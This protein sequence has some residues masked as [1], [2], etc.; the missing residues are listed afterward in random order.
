MSRWKKI[1]IAAAM[2]VAVLMAA[3]YAFLSFY[4]FNKFKPMIA[5]TV[6]NA[7]GRELTIAGDIEFELGIRPTLIVEEVSFQNASWSST[8]DLVRVK[9]M[10][11]RVAFLPLIIGKFDF[12]HLVLIEPTVIAEFD[13]SGTSN[14]SFEMPGD[15]KDES[16][17]APLPLI[18]SDVII[19]KGRFIYKD[20]RSDVKFS[21][22][23][24]RLDAEIPG[25][26]EPL[27]LDFKGAFDDKP[28]TLRG[29]V[30]PIWAWVQP[31]YSLTANL[32]ATAGGTTAM[33]TGDLRDPINFKNLAFD[34]KAQ[35]SS[36]A[37]ITRRAGISGAPE[38]GAFKLSA[39]VSD[40]AGSLAVE[41]L[42]V[43]IG[44]QELVA[45]SLTGDLRDVFALQGVNL[46]FT[47]QGQDSANLTQFG[48]PALPERGAFQVSAQISDPEAK[49]FT[50][51]DLSVVLGEN[52]V[53]GQVILNLVEKNPLLTARLT[54]QKFRFGQ[55]NLD[56]KLT[57]PLEKPAI[58]KIDL[59]LGTPEL[60]EIRLNGIVDDL[61]ELQ[62]VDIDFQASGKDLANLEQITGQP[63]PV[64]GAFSA[65]GKVMIPIHKNLKI[66]DLKITVG[67]NNFT[68]A[69]NLD[70]KGEQ[71]QLEANLSLP[72]LDLPSVLLPHLAKEGWAEG[73]GQV[74]PIKLAVKLTGFTQEI[75]VKKVDLQAGTLASAELRLSGSVANLMAQHGIDLRFSLRGNELAKLKEIIAQPYLFAPMPGQGAYALT[76][77]VSDS[78]ANVF[79][80]DNFKFKLADTELTGRLDFNLAAQPPKYEV[81]LSAPKFNLK[82]FPIPK[83][84]AYANLNKIDD[85]GPL[86]INSKMILEGDQLSLTQLEMQA[87]TEQLAAVQIKGSIKDLTT[88]S[89]IDM[90][91]NF[92]GNEVANLAKITVQSIPLKGAYSIS[93][94][95][96]DPAQ[97]KYK[98]GDLVLKLGQN[99]ITGSLDLNLSA[100]QF[101]LATDLA[102]PKFTLQP[103][104][105]PALEDIS[106]IKDLGPLKLAL[107]LT[108]I[109]K[110]LSLDN[111]DFKL[112]REDLIEVV[113][114]GT[115]KDLSAVQGMKLEFS[116]MG[117]DMS[118][119]EKLGGPEVP[120]EGA[121]NVSG[122][123]I[124]PAPKIYK[125]PAFNAVWGKNKGKGWLE[126]N[127]SAKRPQLRAELSTEK[128]DLQPLFAEDK[129]ERTVKAQSAPPA[130]SKAQ[131]SKSK[132]KT[133]KTSAKKAKVFPAE[134]LPLEGLKEIDANIKFRDKQVLLPALALDDV[135]LDIFL[136]DGNLEIKPFKFKI[137]GGNADVQ[138]ALRSQENPAALATNLNI[139]QL[140]IGPMLDK[141]RYPRDVEGNLDVDFKLDSS[142]NSVAAL[143]AGLNGN[144]RIAMSDGRTASKY[145]EL[146]E[147][148]LGSGVLRMLNPFE[149]KRQYT[150]INCFVNQIEIKDGLADVKILLDTDRTSIFGAGDVNLKSESLDLGIK[151]TPKKGAGP[152]NVSF[153]FKELSQPFRLGG[154]LA[155]PHLAVDPGR[156]AFVIGKMA[157]AVALGPVGIAAFFADVSVGKKDACAVALGTATIEGQPPDEKEKEKKSGGFFKRLFRK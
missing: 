46:N 13:S 109:G 115:I 142:G 87:G 111:L 118:N 126:L 60:A 33:I 78:T 51:S 62:G 14:F 27:Q 140:E 74:R 34:I 90:N 2:V 31:G 131:K 29:T 24:D 98:I 149:E 71:P 61:R 89:G 86:K 32:T 81:N 95:L 45:I 91:V 136:K 6:K 3:I 52:E 30:G 96:T 146:L 7:T 17:M 59:K 113:L 66:P 5:K 50:V 152:A 38:L 100:K 21:V 58:Q 9:R 36:V 18:F 20:A 133:S 120:L 155:N 121:F 147:K 39:R 43:Q 68:G 156:T 110:K 108:G 77:H 35:G 76:G 154:T 79:K 57:G 137:G 144:T 44:S 65:T 48:L 56:L 26:D 141:L 88:Q 153:S 49:V 134:P 42:D 127:L 135:I 16:A 64:R 129:K 4:D 23:I 72:K 132:T 150:P 11:V 85:L 83:D 41:K 8:P 101:Q 138:F 106:H 128:L 105:L 119:F 117:N 102:S 12:A 97:K 82:P 75:A 93:G 69:L 123:F 63:F 47:A 53:D 143:M 19:Q 125:L 103:V 92:R 116:A 139:N 80:V 70:L 107:K 112:G 157:G 22:S 122:Q 40:S 145:L 94:R 114:K 37:E 28:F 25:F 55:L 148:Y 15:Q 104:T 99:N 151:P 1:L 124:D 84:A 73:L 67:K 10:E 54:S 130:P